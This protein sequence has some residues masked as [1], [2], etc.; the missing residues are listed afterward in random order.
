M[1]G[2]REI[3]VLGKSHPVIFVNEL[4]AGL[5]SGWQDRVNLVGRPAG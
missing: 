4:Q 3:K 2:R 5:S 1:A